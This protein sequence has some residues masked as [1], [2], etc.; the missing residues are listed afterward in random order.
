[1]GT[2][3]DIDLAA[4]SR[5]AGWYG[6]ESATEETTCNYGLNVDLQHIASQGG[7]VVSAS[8]DTGEVRAIE[9]HDHPFFVGTL[10]QPQ[11]ISR[12]QRP[13]PVLMAFVQAVA[14]QK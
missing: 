14:D 5:L 2:T 10:Y 13:H 12:P 6:V 7:L 4:G 3:I 9:R 1:M 8:D 11:R